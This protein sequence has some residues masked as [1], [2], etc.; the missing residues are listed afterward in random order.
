MN[1]DD[2]MII[3]SYYEEYR[4]IKGI[5]KNYVQYFS[6]LGLLAEFYELFTVF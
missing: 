3:K 1:K 6:K 5:L 2:I 4:T